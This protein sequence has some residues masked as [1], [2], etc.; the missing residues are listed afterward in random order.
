MKY[1][2]MRRKLGSGDAFPG[3]TGAGERLAGL[4]ENRDINALNTRFSYM[5]R[6]K[7]DYGIS[8]LAK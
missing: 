3:K 1:K 5:T 6:Q 8:V 4:N 7:V 2:G